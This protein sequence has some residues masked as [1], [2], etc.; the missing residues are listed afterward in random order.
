LVLSGLGA[1]VVETETIAS[2]AALSRVLQPGDLFLVL[3]AED[4]VPVGLAEAIRNQAFVLVATRRKWL[5]RKLE[6]D[7]TGIGFEPP[8]LEAAVRGYLTALRAKRSST[9]RPAPPRP[10]DDFHA[11]IKELIAL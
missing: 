8:S 3:G 10:P 9:R 11:K 1:N 6:A 4:T 7:N 2:Q 5:Q